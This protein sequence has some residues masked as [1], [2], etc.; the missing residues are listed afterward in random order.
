LPSG[1]D[2]AVLAPGAMEAIRDALPVARRVPLYR[3]RACGLVM[4]ERPA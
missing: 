1:T 2:P 4:N 3:A